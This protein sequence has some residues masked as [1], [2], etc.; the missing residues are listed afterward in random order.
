VT[1]T[2][3]RLGEGYY[4]EDLKVD[5]RF[6]TYRRTIT[7]ADLVGF[8][9]ATGMLETIFIDVGHQGAISGRP[10]PAALTYCLIEGLLMQ[11]MLRGVG[12]ALLELS[13]K[14][15]APVRVGDSVWAAVTISALRPT[16]TGGRAVVTST[17]EVFNQH[18]GSVLIY[19]VKRLIAGRSARGD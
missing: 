16:S 4:W 15:L 5:D 2:S 11:T 14:A 6:T 17:V 18:G 12:L 7:E 19:D 10:V 3:R 13:Q 8:I 9:N 1:D